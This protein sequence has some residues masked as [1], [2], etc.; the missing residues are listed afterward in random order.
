LRPLRRTRALIAALTH[1][2]LAGP[3]AAALRHIRH[4]L[5]LLGD[6]VWN[7]AV[8]Q[9]LLRD[10]ATPR[11][12]LA[13]QRAHL[14][15]GVFMAGVAERLGLDRVVR[16]GSGPAAAALKRNPT[17][18]AGTLEAVLGAWYLRAGLSPILGFVRRLLSQPAAQA[19]GRA[20]L[21]AKSA[22]QQLA[23]RRFRTMPSYRILERTG[24]EHSPE[25]LVE[26]SVGGAPLG[27][28]RGKSRRG[29]EQAAAHAA[30]EAL[31]ASKLPEDPKI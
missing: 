12:D 18:L 1:A 30:C 22:L 5:E 11:E 6:G 8:L 25:F 29:A 4:R 7:L 17:V 13:R 20:E 24:N 10:A 19:T 31:T 16:T 27:V 23:S 14:A 21:D 28:G 9:Y 15:G 3:E 2:S 26:V